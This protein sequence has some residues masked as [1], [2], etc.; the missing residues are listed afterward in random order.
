VWDNL[1]D[2]EAVVQHLGW[3]RLTL[4]ASSQFGFAAVPYAVS[5]AEN[6]EA[7]ILWQASWDYPQGSENT[8]LPFAE[9]ARRSMELFARTFSAG[10][11]FAP[12]LKYKRFIAAMT[13]EDLLTALDGLHGA[14]LR[15]I[16]PSLN[17]PTLIIGSR[18]SESMPRLE[19]SA[20][21]QA[22]LVPSAHLV[23]FDS[24]R[25]YPV[26]LTLEGASPAALAMQQF[27]TGLASGDGRRAGESVGRTDLSQRELE[28]LRL[29]AAGKSS[30]EIGE[31]LV[32]SRRTVERHVANIY[33]KT[34]THGRAQLATYALRNSLT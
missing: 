31:E 5:H 32:L 17:V 12:E 21:E 13:R 6:V 23:L 14:T 20:R 34:E 26:G 19:V 22:T 9:L 16:L 11:G 4:I 8:L 10:Q 28:V 1:R 2:L 25:G 27:L 7:L 30:R 24:E 3:S 33:L 18:S 29:V 15:S